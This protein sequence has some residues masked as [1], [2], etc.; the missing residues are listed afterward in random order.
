[1]RITPEQVYAIA[2]LKVGD[3][4]NIKGF[5]NDNPFKIKEK[6]LLDKL[7]CDWT[8]ETII[9]NEFE[10]VESKIWNIDEIKRGDFIWFVG[11]DME[12]RHY[13]YDGSKADVKVIAKNIAFKEEKYAEEYKEKLIEFNEKYKKECE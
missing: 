7:G 3:K 5:D 13:F 10:K 8:I 4:I 2:G 11:F 1:M 9:S 12:I 6:F